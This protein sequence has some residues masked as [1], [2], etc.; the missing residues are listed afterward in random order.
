VLG[1]H[2]NIDTWA[3]DLEGREGVKLSSLVNTI[4]NKVF[5]TEDKKKY[6]I[7]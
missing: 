3:K 6:K 1:I 2:N 5:T 7:D 4:N